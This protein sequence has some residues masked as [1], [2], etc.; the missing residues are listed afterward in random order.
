[1]VILLCFS[2]TDPVGQPSLSLF[3]GGLG[4]IILQ[5]HDLI[6]ILSIISVGLRKYILGGNRSLLP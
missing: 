3:Q 6:P 5:L 2:A 4:E 1:M